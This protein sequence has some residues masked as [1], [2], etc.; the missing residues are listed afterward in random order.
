MRNSVLAIDLGERR[1]GLALAEP[2]RALE[3]ERR[4]KKIPLIIWVI[5]RLE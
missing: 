5:K 3:K 1:V 4:T 2:G